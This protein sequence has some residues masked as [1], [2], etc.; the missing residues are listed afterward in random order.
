MN[1]KIKLQNN[2]LEQSGDSC[3]QKDLE[4]SSIT[5]ICL[6]GNN[7][8]EESHET[9]QHKVLEGSS[10]NVISAIVK[11][12]FKISTPLPLEPSPY[13]PIHPHIMYLLRM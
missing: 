12:I 5:K 7:I 10:K 2:V 4:D 11:N 13:S 8:L 6:H 9:C 1:N 3:P